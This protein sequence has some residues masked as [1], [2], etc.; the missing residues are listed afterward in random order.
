ME[1]N[2][3]VDFCGIKNLLRLLEEHGFSEAELKKIEARIAVQIG[4]SI[5]LC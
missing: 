3:N 1:R 2:P 4:V 5:I